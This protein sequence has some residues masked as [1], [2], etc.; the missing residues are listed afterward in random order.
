MVSLGF[1]CCIGEMANVGDRLGID[2]NRASDYVNN[3][4]SPDV[5]ASV[6]HLSHLE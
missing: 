1:E 3:L 4:A 5:F 6:N 2:S